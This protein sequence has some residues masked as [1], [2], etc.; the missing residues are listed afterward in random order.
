MLQGK[1]Q[2]GLP[3]LPQDP[4][5]SHSPVKTLQILVDEAER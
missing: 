4:G 5:S 3:A 1:G 2:A